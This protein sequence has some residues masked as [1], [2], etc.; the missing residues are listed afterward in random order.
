MI[1]NVC[2]ELLIEDERQ[3]TSQGLLN[4][5]LAGRDTTASL[6]SNLFSML[7]RQ[8]DVYAKLAAEIQST[9][10]TADEPPTLE[11]LKSMK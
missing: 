9:I 11:S 6:L 2:G 7:A 4:L 1:F 10:P 3:L 8:P 5:L